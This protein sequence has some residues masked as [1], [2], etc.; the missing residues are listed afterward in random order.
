[1]SSVF[2]E[3]EQTNGTT[4]AVPTRERTGP[5]DTFPGHD[6]PGNCRDCSPAQI[7]AWA[8][9]DID[10][11][12][13]A[14]RFAG[15]FVVVAEDAGRLA[16]FAELEANGHIDRVYVSADDQGQGVA[17][18]VLAAV[19][20]E[21]RRLGLVRLLVEASITA[22]PFFESQGFAMLAPQVVVRR[23]VEFVNYRMERMLAEP[24]AEADRP[25]DGR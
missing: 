17:R 14:S 6:P 12:E 16:G 9:D 21:A 7:A 4:A 20:G 13:R 5:A 11:D 23:G 24:G 8:S 10:P 22:R 15:R 25:R 2:G 3:S 18:A 1:V 19:V